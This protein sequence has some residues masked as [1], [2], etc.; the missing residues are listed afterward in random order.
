MS[1][2]KRCIDCGIPITARALELNH[3]GLWCVECERARRERLSASFAAIS[4]SFG[5]DPGDSVATQPT[6]KAGGE[7]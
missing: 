4:K 6:D 3:T 2:G 5:I 1:A 7:G